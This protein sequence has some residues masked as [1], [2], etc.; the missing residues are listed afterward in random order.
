M[1]HCVPGSLCSPGPTCTAQ[2]SSGLHVSAKVNVQTLPLITAAKPPQAQSC[3]W[4]SRRDCCWWMKL[5]SAVLRHTLRTTNTAFVQALWENFAQVQMLALSDHLYKYKDHYSSSY[6]LHCSV[7][8]LQFYPD[9]T[10]L[11]QNPSNTRKKKT[12]VLRDG[13]QKLSSW[14]TAWQPCLSHCQVFWRSWYCEGAPHCSRPLPVLCKIN[15]SGLRS[16]NVI[17]AHSFYR[18]LILR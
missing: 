2:P 3:R 1:L 15:C 8:L 9:G 16:K 11:L 12:T 7:P 14:A 13:T 10:N 18:Y 6:A 4:V 17:T 5:S